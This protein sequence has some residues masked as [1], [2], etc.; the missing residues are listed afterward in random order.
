MAFEVPRRVRYDELPLDLNPQR[1]ETGSARR[2][3]GELL[4]KKARLFSYYRALTPCDQTRTQSTLSLA[5]TF[6]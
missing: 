3:L 2:S 6:P 1:R 4:V 5:V